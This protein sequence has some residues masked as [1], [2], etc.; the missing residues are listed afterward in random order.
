MHLP[1]H[2]ALSWLVGHRLEH[3]R[4]RALVAWAGVVPDLDALSLLGGVEAYGRWH[5]VVGHGLPAALLT[6]ALAAALGKDRAKAAALAFVTFHGHLV[7]DL[8]GSGVEW[9]IQYL[10]PLSTW[11]LATPYGWPLASWQNVVAMVLG[12]AASVRTAVTR[13]RTFAETF[14]PARAEAAVVAT[15]RRRLLGEAAAPS[16]VPGAER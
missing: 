15:L 7:C 11:E 8:A 16:A 1:T 12:L 13:R 3:R 9:T 4:D 10:W 14:L 2:L 6:T 5:H